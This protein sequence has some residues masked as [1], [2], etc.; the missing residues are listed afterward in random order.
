MIFMELEHR[1]LGKY[2]KVAP[3][4]AG[5]ALL[6]A[7]I[8][9]VAVIEHSVGQRPKRLIK[10]GPEAFAPGPCCYLKIKP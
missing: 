9:L 4:S 5:I 10:E 3:V 1:E 8:G 7:A 6:L 2:A